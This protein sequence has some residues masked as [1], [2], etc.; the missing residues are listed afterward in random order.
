MEK[1]VQDGTISQMK[2]KDLKA[3]LKDKKL[4]D[5]GTNPLLV[6]ASLPP[7]CISADDG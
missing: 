3:F 7:L 4:K 6:L 1:A 2:Q 5:S